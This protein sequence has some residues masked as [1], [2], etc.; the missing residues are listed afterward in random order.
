MSLTKKKEYRK[1]FKDGWLE[2]AGWLNGE[3]D[4]SDALSDESKGIFKAILELWIDEW[5]NSV[6]LK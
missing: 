6:K 5:K 1:G 3:I 4:V 2:L